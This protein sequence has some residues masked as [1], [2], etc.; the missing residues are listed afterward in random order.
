MY[1]N[2]NAG[3]CNAR[4]PHL[5][6]DVSR[7]FGQHSHHV[8]EALI[9]GDVQRRAQRVVQE[10]DVGAFAQQQSRNLRLITE[11]MDG[12]RVERVRGRHVQK[13]I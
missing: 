6:I 3:E 2:T 5:Q 7:V 11:R 4:R 10:V 13:I 9:Y 8:G 1:L 12:E